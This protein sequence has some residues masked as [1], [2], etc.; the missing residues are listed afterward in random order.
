MYQVC[1]PG[2]PPPGTVP[3]Q[4]QYMQPG[5]PQYMYPA[6]PQYM[7]PAQPQYAQPAQPQYAMDFRAA[8]AEQPPPEWPELS[9]CVGKTTKLQERRSE[10]PR[11]MG[12]KEKRPGEAEP[13]L[14][15]GAVEI[16]LR[17]HLEDIQG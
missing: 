4:P 5:E 11:Y 8:A 7:Y 17:G 3:G 16:T 15:R 6:Q 14:R 10:E 1:E 2:Q 13:E 9:N 12:F